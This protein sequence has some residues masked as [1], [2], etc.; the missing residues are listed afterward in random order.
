MELTKSLF[1]PRLDAFVFSAGDILQCSLEVLARVI[2]TGRVVVCVEIRVDE[3][4][5]AIEV[6]RRHLLMV[7]A[8]MY[9]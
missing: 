5:Q 6:F 9:W 7:L 2:E 1:R 4:D 8:I 3:L